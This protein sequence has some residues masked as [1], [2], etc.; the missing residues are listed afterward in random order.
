MTTISSICVYCGSSDGA[1][2]IYREAGFQLGQAIAEAGLRLVYGGGTRGIMGAVAEGAMAH[3]GKVT[4]I[5]PRFLMRKEAPEAAGENLDELVVTETMHERKHALFQRSGAFVAMP[6]GIGTVEEIVEM[7]TWA[8]LGHHSK[9]MVFGNIG[10]YWGPMLEMMD[11]MMTEGFIHTANRVKPLVID[12]VG[13]IVPAI[14]EAAAKAEKPAGE[15][16]VIE[17]M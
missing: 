11:H 13:G 4:G 10:G 17:R 14:L 3:G 9:P 1:R 15:P 8:Q 2:E 12:D 5:I 6:G 7:M 16:A